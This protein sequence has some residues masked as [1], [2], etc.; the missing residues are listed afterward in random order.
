MP[1]T[2]PTPPENISLAAAAAALG[3]SRSWARDQITLGWLERVDVPGS[4]QIHV[5]TRSVAR[6]AARKRAQAPQRP[7][8]YLIVDNT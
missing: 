3:R 6:I 8:L 4:R 7:R 2:D 5:S 1:A